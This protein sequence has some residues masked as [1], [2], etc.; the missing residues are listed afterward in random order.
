MC[1]CMHV[2]VYIGAT[3]FSIFSGF[4]IARVNI[5]S[6]WLWMYYLGFLRYPLS[7]GVANEMRGLQFTCEASQRI[8]F[9]PATQ[10]TPCELP[11]GQT[12][13]CPIQCGD[14]LAHSVGIATEG[15]DYTSYLII[16]FAYA[17]GL[18]VLGFLAFKY[19]NHI[20]R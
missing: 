15:A 10:S 11:A 13:I 16:V 2:H 6:G 3:I 7:F 9:N 14:G 5:P 8:P 18:R 19:I 17:I 20:K 4:F 12:T 1:T